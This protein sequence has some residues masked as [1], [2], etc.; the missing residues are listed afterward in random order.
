MT[1]IVPAAPAAPSN[2]SATPVSRTQINLSWTDTSTN[3][4]G[5]KIERCAGS[6]CTNFVQTGT[7]GANVTS[8][9]N[10]GLTRNTTY[11]YRVRAYNAGGDS[12]YSNIV[13]ATTA[14]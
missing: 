6:T 11:R 9:A 7:V 1:T 3:E 12:A 8:I 4:D 14:R 5:F 10:T 2:L 13:T